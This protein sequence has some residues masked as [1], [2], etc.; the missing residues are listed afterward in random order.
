VTVN[1]SNGDDVIL[2]AGVSDGER[3]VVDGPKDLTDA[4]KVKEKKP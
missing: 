1:G 2:T 3:V 4:A